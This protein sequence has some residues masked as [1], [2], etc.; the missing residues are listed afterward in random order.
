MALLFRKT[1][2]L[3]AQLDEYLDLVDQGS[4]VFQQGLKLYFENRNDEFEQRLH[5]LRQKESKGDSLRRD[6]ESKLYT[7]TLIPEARGDVLG[8]LESTDKVLNKIASILLDFSIE[9]PDIAKDLHSLYLDLA[10]AA[11]SAMESMI[12]AIRTYFRDIGAVRDHINK[13]LFMKKSLI[14]SRKK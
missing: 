5:E 14:K 8:L 1:K 3:E 7:Q 11:A 13:V 6:I 4:M 2:E 12:N 9:N 10:K